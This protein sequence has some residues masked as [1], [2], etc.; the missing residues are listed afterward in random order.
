M[1][2]KW[3]GL[4]TSILTASLIMTACAG[5]ASGGDNTDST[6]GGDGGNGG[7]EQVT[8]R[9]SWWG[10]QERHDMTFKIIEM[11]EDANPHVKIEPEFTG[12]DGY[13]ERMAAQ[14]AGNNLP[15][16]MQQNFGE[17]LNLYASQNLLTDLSEFLDDG[18]IDVSQVDE[19]VL[20]SGVK[21]GKQLGIPSGMN[22]LTVI[23]S[24][25]MLD[26]AGVEIDENW[27]WEDF[28]EIAYQV[29]EELDTYGTRSFDPKNIFEYYLREKGHT[30]FNEDGTGLGYDDDQLLTD[31][32]TLEKNMVDDGVAPGYDVVQ[33]I[34]GI[35]DELIVHGTAPFDFRWSNQVVTMSSAAD[36]SFDLNVL[37][38]ENNNQAMY[39]KPAMLWSVSENSQNK[40]EAA[41]FIDFFTNTAEVFETI[42]SDRGVPINA[43][44]RD[45][46]QADL[47]EVETKI[48]EYID[49]VTENSSPIDT[50]FPAESTEVLQALENVDERVMY[51]Q[52]TP[53]EGA[54]EFRRTAEMILGN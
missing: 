30:L 26:E 6:G 15:D 36:Y 4:T 13:F 24:Q 28:E 40:E 5:G 23:Y 10:S 43:E 45:G 37:P 31:F 35:E 9:M 50:N 22:A 41:K 19:L 46:M 12:F 47:N 21:D 27:T 42:G 44:I 1:K 54:E 34:Q 52:L 53:E 20:E 17:Y 7:D 32:L 14:A 25:E 38:G 11:Y 49:Y 51:G 48:Y 8:L 16:I 2:K 39:L 3:F 33:Q 18:T 29:H